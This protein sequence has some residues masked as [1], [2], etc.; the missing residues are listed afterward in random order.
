MENKEQ[1]VI[2]ED[3]YLRLITDQERASWGMTKDEW[4]Y[5]KAMA[6]KI[7]ECLDGLRGW[8]E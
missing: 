7:N 6:E 4:E 2:T 1:P 8:E 3:G 5:F